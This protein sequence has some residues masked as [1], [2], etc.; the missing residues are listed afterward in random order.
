MSIQKLVAALLFVIVAGC[1][2]PPETAS[3]ADANAKEEVSVIDSSA[4]LSPEAFQQKVMSAGGGV[5]FVFGEDRPFTQCHASTVVQT[6]DGDLLSAWFGGTEEKNP[7][8]AVWLSRFSGETWSPPERAAK[9]REAAHWNPVLFRDAEDVIYLFFKVG[10]D[11]PVWQTYWMQSE[12]G[13]RTWNDPQELVP[14]DVGGRGPVKNK[15]IVLSDGAWLA[16]ASTEAKRWEPFADRST[17]RG[18]TWTRSANWAIDRNTLKGI[19]AIQP[20]FWESAPGCVHALMR[21]S[22][23]RI[24]RTDSEDGGR[25]WAP[26]YATALPNNNSGIDALR[27]EDGRILLVFNPVRMNWGPR[28]PLDLAVSSDNGVTWKTIAHLEDNPD[29]NSEFS[30]PAIVRTKEGVAITYTWQRQR[31]RCWR[32]PLSVL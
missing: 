14:G 15:P 13:G 27:L 2:T 12:N 17:D 18:M 26:V 20:T 4:V 32:I 5:D 29:K 28:T 6:A 16:P 24:W 23:G 21:T 9:V 31:I 19:G 22:C 10:E 30:Y 11:V 7:D 25:T 8:V 3:K 1:A